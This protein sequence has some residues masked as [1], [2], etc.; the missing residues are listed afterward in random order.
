MHMPAN[1]VSLITKKRAG[2]YFTR[3][4]RKK[5]HVHLIFAVDAKKPTYIIVTDIIN[6]MIEFSDETDG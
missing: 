1:I 3:C 2:A 5:T 6:L 4:H